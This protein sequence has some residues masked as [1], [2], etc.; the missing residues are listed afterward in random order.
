MHRTLNCGA[1][2]IQGV[3]VLENLSWYPH[4]DVVYSVQVLRNWNERKVE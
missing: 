4:H 1:Q 3:D 2:L